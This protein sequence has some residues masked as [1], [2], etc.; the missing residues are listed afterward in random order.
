MEA[1][2]ASICAICV[3]TRDVLHQPIHLLLL[4]AARPLLGKT[5]DK[6]V[7]LIRLAT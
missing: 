5:F 3:E 7:F 6:W 2:G 4:K 1:L